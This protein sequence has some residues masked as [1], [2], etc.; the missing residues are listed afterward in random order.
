[1]ASAV[2]L[3]DRVRPWCVCWLFLLMLLVPDRRLRSI[4]EATFRLVIGWRIG[5]YWAVGGALDELAQLGGAQLQCRPRRMQDTFGVIRAW[6][7]WEV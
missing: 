4:P 3:D 6:P 2:Q 1:M 5:T 7:F